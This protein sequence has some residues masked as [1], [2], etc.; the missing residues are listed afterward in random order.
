M[1]SLAFSRITLALSV[2]IHRNTIVILTS[3][4][5]PLLLVKWYVPQII[6]LYNTQSCPLIT[7]CRVCLLML[8]HVVPYTNSAVGSCGIIYHLLC[9][10]CRLNNMCYIRGFMSHVSS[11]LH[12]DSPQWHGQHI[13]SP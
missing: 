10:L 9:W 8:V 7:L 2:E 11:I 5:D 4:S 3:D 1:D 13:H 6:I 12:G